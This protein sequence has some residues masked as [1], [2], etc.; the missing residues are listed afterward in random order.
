MALVTVIRK[1]LV[2]MGRGLPAQALA[3]AFGVRGAEAVRVHHCD[4]SYTG[5][6]PSGRLGKD[7]G[8]LGIQ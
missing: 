3:T 6:K 5:L 1:V 7:A 4:P 8:I 2:V